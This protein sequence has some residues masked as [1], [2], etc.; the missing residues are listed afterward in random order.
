MDSM[1]NKLSRAGLACIYS[2]ILFKN[3]YLYFDNMKIRVKYLGVKLL[4]TTRD[5]TEYRFFYKIVEDSYSNQSE[6]EA[7]SI[8]HSFEVAITGPMQV[9]WLFNGVLAKDLYKILFEIGRKHILKKIKEGNLLEPE[10]IEVN[11]RKFSKIP[12][13][14]PKEILNPESHPDDIIII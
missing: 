1:T 13:F 2:Y 5:A 4:P 14:D 8:Y 7:K 12:P 3:K 9:V 6:E 10:K 11:S